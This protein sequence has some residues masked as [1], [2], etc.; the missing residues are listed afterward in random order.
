MVIFHRFL[1]VYQ[2]G[3]TWAM[4]CDTE[5]YGV[6]WNDIRWST[7]KNHHI[8]TSR[9]FETSPNNVKRPFV[10]PLVTSWAICLF[11]PWENHR[12]ISMHIIHLNNPKT[13]FFQHHPQNPKPLFFIKIYHILWFK[14]P[15]ITILVA[16]FQL[17]FC[18]PSQDLMQL[19][20]SHEMTDVVI[21]HEHR[22]EPDGMVVCHLPFGPTAYFGFQLRDDWDDND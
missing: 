14:G 8:S 22:G 11:L 16:V 15:W 9:C 12:N 5:W 21:V 17:G 6:I 10:S 18:Q 13:D 4:W 20:R 1:Y 19:A 2:A 7:F 3:Y